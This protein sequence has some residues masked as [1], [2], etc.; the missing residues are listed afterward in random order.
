MN[1]M[2]FL[3]LHLESLILISLS[4]SILL[5]LHY[6]PNNIHY[7]AQISSFDTAIMYI[8]TKQSACKAFD[9][10]LS[11]SDIVKDIASW[12]TQISPM[13]MQQLEYIYH[14]YEQIQIFDGISVCVSERLEHII[15]K[16]EPLQAYIVQKIAKQVY[17]FTRDDERKWR[18]EL[19]KIGVATLPSTIKQIHRPSDD[20]PDDACSIEVDFDSDVDERFLCNSNGSIIEN[21]IELLNLDLKNEVSARFPIGTVRD[22]LL[23]KIDQKIIISS[24]QINIPA[25]RNAHISASGFDFNKKILVIKTAMEHKSLLLDIRCLNDD[26]ELDSMIGH[27]VAYTGGDNN[28]SVIIKTV[29]EEKEI[30][31]PIQKIFLIKTIKR[32]VFFK[33]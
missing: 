9:Q 17:L 24:S 26:G 10:N 16:Y 18:E 1:I 8:I 23:A 32:S 2:G 5:F 19:I 6:K 4:R 27:P 12:S 14:E 25:K 29:P 22:E 33:V 28:G 30:A 7:Y 20:E 13:L 15:D 11:V 31:I 21:K 3:V